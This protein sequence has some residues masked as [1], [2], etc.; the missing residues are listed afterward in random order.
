MGATYSLSQS[1]K[2]NH[3]I[4][5]YDMMQQRLRRLTR[6]QSLDVSP[7]FAPDSQRLVF[8]SDRSGSPQLYTLNIAAPSPIRLTRTEAYNTSPFWS[9]RDDI[10]AFVG[11]GSNQALDLYTIKPDGTRR[12]R[13]TQGQRFHTA[14]TW[15]PDGRTL[16]GMSLRGTAWERHLVQLDPNRAVPNLPE[17]KSLCLAPQWVAYRA[18]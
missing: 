6:H 7:S 16:M 1:I 2:G 14:P 3:D 13:H 10:I 11:R 5:I 15:L 4:F 12:Q 9:P 8:S 18:R 17:P